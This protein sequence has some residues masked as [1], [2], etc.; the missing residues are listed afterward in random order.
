[1]QHWKVEL[2]TQQSLESFRNCRTNCILWKKK[3][4]S[5]STTTACKNKT[6]TKFEK[7]ICL[8]SETGLQGLVEYDATVST[9]GVNAEL[10][11]TQAMLTAHSFTQTLIITAFKSTHN[12][13]LHTIL[14][15]PPPLLSSPIFT[16]SL[17]ASFLSS[18][19][20]YDLIWAV[21]SWVGLNKKGQESPG[22]AETP[23]KMRRW[24]KRRTRWC[25][26][27]KT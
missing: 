5:A 12:L 8:L 25:R 26:W 27:F 4:F 20:V 24:E 14:H 9:A 11:A 23:E 1:M 15:H 18:P 22:W 21:P 6:W 16:E 19:N 7:K 17:C 2:Y 3:K 10:T 13:I